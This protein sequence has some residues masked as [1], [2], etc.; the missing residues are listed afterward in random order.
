[1][2][3]HSFH[4]S[5][6]TSRPA[7]LAFVV[8]ILFSA[9][10]WALPSDATIASFKAA[11]DALDSDPAKAYELASK[12]ETI[13]HADDVRLRLLADSALRS[14]QALKADEHL[15][16]LL[17]LTEDG[18]EKLEIELER[19]EVAFLLGDVD[20]A[21]KLVAAASKHQRKVR[22]RA[23][24][25][26]FMKSRIMR[27]EHDVALAK[28]GEGSKR[29]K[30]LAKQLLVFYPAEDATHR[31]GLAAEVDDL[32]N[33]QRM[34]RAKNL[35]DSWSYHEAR[36]EF[37]RL[38]KMDRY[39]EES[40]WHLGVIGLRKLRDR[41]E[42]AQQIFADLSRNSSKYAEKS[43]YYYARSFMRQEKYDKALEVFEDYAKRFPSGSHML[44]VRYYR[45]WLHYDHRKNDAAIK[46]FDEFIDTYGR[47]S[48]KSS[49]IYG[50]KA[51]ALMREKRWKDAVDAWDDMMP[52][53]NPVVAG[54]AMYWK[55]HALW[56]LD[57]KKG[58]IESLDRL[59]ERYPLTYY[60]MLGEMMRA[61]IETGKPKPASQVWWPPREQVADD[62]PRIDVVA[63]K[64]DLEGSKADRW[65]RTK[66]LALLGEKH[67]ARDAL[68][69]IEDDLLRE[70]PSDNRKEWIHSLGRF[71]GDY[72][73]MW[74]ASTGGRLS[75][76]TTSVPD[77]TD[78]SWAMAYPRAYAEI[79]GEVTDEFDLPG[80]LVWAIMRQESRYKPGAISFTNAVGALQMIP[81]T[82]R[83]VARDL[84]TVYDVRT[85]FRPEVGFR[86]SGY[87]MQ[88]LLEVFSGLYVPMAASYNS[89][90]V[91]VAR[92]FERNPDA[93]FPWLIE[94]FEYNEGRAY[95]R[96]VAEHMLR[97][98]YLYEQNEDRRKAIL[99]AMFPLS[100][101]IEL[102]EDVGY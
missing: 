67:L 86:F 37:E 21:S 78:L 54:K 57:D 5:A 89:G 10:A 8:A 27:L 24:D 50:F 3:R 33:G 77:T 11:R 43:T 4:R 14:G 47:R 49:Y 15:A 36:D 97:Y 94:E 101:D 22:G 76:M 90:P 7:V 26:R 48:H 63:K 58:A 95:C 65:E 102:P 80:Y 31:P 41:P 72:N 71:V 17:A 45:G 61:E 70:I 87:Y 23:A 32:S 34:A 51:W 12:L 16:A 84:G 96:K 44:D 75:A 35:Y 30:S 82:A 6:T 60:Q 1:M 85:F 73:E 42:E 88:R 29:A 98:I 92:W 19:A 56:K 99:D 93:S 66:A 52:F 69:P 59:R 18:E 83:L 79:V 53:G 20:R 28:D 100:R 39:R 9:S 40:R 68:G 64:F 46:G 13:P 74:K 55:A 25:R 2:A 91:V 38:A 62:A 81:K